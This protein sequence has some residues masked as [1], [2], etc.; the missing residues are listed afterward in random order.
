M[1]RF[2]IVGLPNVGK[3]T[4]FNALTNSRAP[5]ENY[6]FCTVEPNVA[7]VAVPDER[8]E[9]I[10]QVA[11][12][13]RM[14][15]A[16]VEFVDIAGLV[17]GASKGAG[18][19]NQFLAQIR[20]VDAIVE[21][22]RCFEDPDVVHVM[23]QVDPERDYQVIKTEL[24]LADL[25]VVERRLEKV[26]K[27][28]RAGEQEA[29][30][31]LAVLE[32]VREALESGS[33]AWAAVGNEEERRHL[34]RLGLLSIKPVLY[35]ANVGEGDLGVPEP[36]LVARLKEAVERD[37]P[38]AVVVGF[39]AKLEAELS[40]LDGEERKEFMEAAGLEQTGLA[41]LIRAGYQLLGLETFFTVGEEEVRAWT[42]RRGTTAFEAAGLIHSDFQ[43]GFIRCETLSWEEFVR[44]GSYKKAREAGMVRSEGRE[45]VVKDGEILL[46]RFNV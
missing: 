14:V 46:F 26:R 4:L 43:R 27:H 39:S 40:E 31:E 1:L 37:R 17:E 33:D 22:V 18:L 24:A 21:V 35:A 15:P 13:P 16:L 42:I 12:R 23:G 44:A 10:N 28:A 7:V 3:S 9:R 29:V 34:E 5:A 30:L 38:G 20:E 11:R 8:L 2:G 25:A 36:P 6:P 45:Y 19:G 41:R 32:R